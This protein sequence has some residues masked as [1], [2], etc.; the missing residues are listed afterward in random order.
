MVNY[1]LIDEAWDSPLM[2]QNQ[3]GYFVLQPDRQQDDSDLLKEN[4]K[5]NFKPKPNKKQ[6]T[7]DYGLDNYNLDK[8]QNFNSGSLETNQYNPYNFNNIDYQSNN[9]FYETDNTTDNSDSD[10]DNSDEELNYRIERKE[11]MSKLNRKIKNVNYDNSDD[12]EIYNNRSGRNNRNDKKNKKE[13][14]NTNKLLYENKIN[15]LQKHIQG[16]E[17]EMYNMKLVENNRKKS[18]FGDI[19]TNEMLIFLSMGI[20]VMITLD[21]FVKLGKHMKKNN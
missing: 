19:N 3:D 9:N 1:S 8:I 12:N 10:D 13:V 21:A 20:F 18:V 14:N 17:S 5:Y 7:S 6:S 4:V 15:E 2:K 16:L 11:R